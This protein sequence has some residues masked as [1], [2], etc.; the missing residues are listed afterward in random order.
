MDHDLR[1]T[2]RSCGS[3]DGERLSTPAHDLSFSIDARAAYERAEDRGALIDEDVDGLRIDLIYS[4]SDMQG[5]NGVIVDRL[6]TAF[7][8]ALAAL[9]VEIVGLGLSAAVA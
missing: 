5:R 3:A 1:G 8:S 7:A 9:V 2:G 6:R 4:L